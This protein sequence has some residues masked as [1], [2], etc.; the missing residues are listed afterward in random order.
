[1]GEAPTEL[2]AQGPVDDIAAG[3]VAEA[4]PEASARQAPRDADRTRGNILAAAAV[5]FASKGLAGARVDAIAEASGANKR[6]IYYYFSS[7]EGLYIAVLERA[8]A[9][10][11]DSERALA[12]DHLEPFDGI[13]RLVEFKFDYFVENPVVIS[14]LNGENMQGGAYLKRT[15]QIADMH[16]SLVD[17]IGALLKRGE[18]SGTMRGGVDPLHLYISISALSYFYFSNAP[19]LSTVFGRKL[20]TPAENRLRRKHA[21]EVILAYL[22]AA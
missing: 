4:P 21:V 15:D 20:A 10:M 18:A 16:A 3:H 9:Q 13:R 14:L 2:T 22:R 6:M 17:T 12:L 7:K 1:M 19:T 5:E 8:Y 11:R